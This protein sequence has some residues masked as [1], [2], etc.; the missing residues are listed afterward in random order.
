MELAAAERS[1]LVVIDLQGKLVERVHRPRLVVAATRRLM[2]IAELF[3]V[4][5]VVTEQYPRGL[6]A[7]HPEVLEVFDA[8][9]VPHR[10]FEKTAFGC[11]AEPGFEEVLSALRPGVP[12]AGRQL[13][14]AGIEAHVC[15]M[16]TVLEALRAGQGVQVC[17]EAVSGR[18]AEHRQWALERMQ[19]AGAA[20]TNH[21]SV[22]FEWARDKDHP[23]FKALSTLLK[24]GQLAG[25]Q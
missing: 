24:E 18:G 10:R 11:C 1:V 17:W 25:E 8:L 23:S 22:A 19:Q 7:T 5:V 16:Q 3:G 2:R 9:T 13:V 12:A 4:P 21:E 15:V 6:G 14:V 20:I